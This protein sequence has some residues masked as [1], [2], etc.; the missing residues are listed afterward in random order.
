MLSNTD[1]GHFG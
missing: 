1:R